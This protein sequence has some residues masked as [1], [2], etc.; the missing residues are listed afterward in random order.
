M[1]AEWLVPLA[2]GV[3]S[4]GGQAFADRTNVRLSR[5]QMRF[6]ERMS[7]TAAQRAVKDYTAAG[8]NPALAYDRPAS[9]PGGASATVGNVGE[10]GVHSAMTAAQVKAN[11]DL[12]KS[13]TDKSQAEAA[14][15]WADAAVKT[16][17]T[18]Q[19]EPTYR[20]EYMARRREAIANAAFGGKYQPHEL[21]RLELDNII[22][23]LEA[24]IME[25]EAK[26]SKMMGMLRPGAR[27]A[28]AVL[29]TIGRLPMITGGARAAEQAVRRLRPT[30]PGIRPDGSPRTKRPR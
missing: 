11:L 21:R 18:G 29:N 16:G 20:D 30:T 28:G 8:L 3:L 25:P 5:E 10:K 15:A 27:D 19:G 14:S 22:K 6:Q 1:A 24:D 17:V 2:T 9:S 26:Y 23:R 12:T 7:S 13:Q 4:A